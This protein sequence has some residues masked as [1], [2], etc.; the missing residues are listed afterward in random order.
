[1]TPYSL[2]FTVF[3]LAAVWMLL[4]SVYRFCGNCFAMPDDP[5]KYYAI[6]RFLILFLQTFVPGVLLYFLA[7]W[8][9]KAAIWNPK[10]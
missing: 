6:S 8:L 9:A 2:A 1:M 4:F 3:R 5:G 7:P 10:E